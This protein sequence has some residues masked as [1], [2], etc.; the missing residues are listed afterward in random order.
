MRHFDAWVVRDPYSIF[1]YYSTGRRWQDTIRTLI[2]ERKIC[3]PIQESISPNLSLPAH[4]Q[5]ECNLL[6]KLPPEIRQMI[7]SY[8]FGAE[9]LRLVTVKNKIRHVRCS[10]STSLTQH[11]NCCPATA[12][13]WRIQNPTAPGSGHA[14]SDLLYPH[15]HTSLPSNLSSSSLGLLLS[16]RAIYAESIDL[17]YRQNTFDVDDLYTFI[18]FASSIGPVLLNTIR[19]LSVQW[20]PVWQPLSGQDHK[21]SIYAHTHSDALWTEFWAVVSGMTGL[22][23]L[24]LSI[25]LGRFTGTRGGGGVVVVAGQRIPLILTEAW[26]LPL[27]SVRGL[28]A[29][30][31]AV[32]AR[33]DPVVKGV[34]EG[35]LVRDAGILR[36][37]LRM[38]MCSKM[39]VELGEMELGLKDF[40]LACALEALREES[41]DVT[42]PRLITAE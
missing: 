41:R 39:G 4:P 29:F 12:A 14:Q 16:C 2:Q 42:G 31:M 26:V 7:W 5:A 8:V 32:T 22:R 40:K 19:R 33:C 21:G 11:R 28:D 18:A 24:G 38:I 17:L 30:E 10:H 15:T 36:D 3:S 34:I 9:T 27:L 1:H 35:E 6:S 37:Q 13:R 23:E 25:D 20:M